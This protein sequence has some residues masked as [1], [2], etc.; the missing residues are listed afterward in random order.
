MWTSIMET[1]NSL[2]NERAV[3]DSVVEGHVDQY[4]LDGT[5]AAVNVPRILLEK[6]EKDMHKVTVFACV[7]VYK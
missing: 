6:V 7:N 5:D 1:L 2:R 3:V 4:T